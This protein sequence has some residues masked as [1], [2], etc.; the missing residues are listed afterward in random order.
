MIW[1]G[2]VNGAAVDDSSAIYSLP[3]TSNLIHSVSSIR[4]QTIRL[5]AKLVEQHQYTMILVTGGV[6]PVAA[7]TGKTQVGPASRQRQPSTDNCAT[8]FR[9]SA[10]PF[11]LTLGIS[12][13]LA[14]VTLKRRTPGQAQLF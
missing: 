1:L 12:C 9:S 5:A 7:R 3:S 10:Q 13:P 6:G 2:G 11:L 4:P 14:L 8:S